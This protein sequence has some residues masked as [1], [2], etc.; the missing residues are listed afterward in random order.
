[1]TTKCLHNVQMMMLDN[2][3]KAD[4]CHECDVESHHTELFN[5]SIQDCVPSLNY[6]DLIMYDNFLRIYKLQ[7]NLNET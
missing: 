2:N 4:H 5:C 3:M 1:M 6:T 7:S